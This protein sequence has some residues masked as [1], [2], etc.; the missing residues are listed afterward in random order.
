MGLLCKWLG[1]YCFFFFVGTENVVGRNEIK[2]FN[3]CFVMCLMYINF[4]CFLYI[5]IGLVFRH[6]IFYGRYDCYSFKILVKSTHFK[7]N[8]FFLILSTINF[9]ISILI[10]LQ[11]M[12]CN[13][14]YKF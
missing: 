7:N 10:I 1:L 6:C 3:G 2:Y 8:T 9:N 4:R 11:E 14:N 5:Y 12:L 13:L